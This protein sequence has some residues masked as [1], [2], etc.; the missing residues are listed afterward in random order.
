MKKKYL[1]ISLT[2]LLISCGSS[3]S[4]QSFFNEHKNEIGV[5]TFQVPNF[6]RSVLSSISPEMNGI[7]SNINDFKFITFNEISVEK[8]RELIQQINLVTANNYKDVLRQNT[9]EKTK[10]L[11]VIEDG[12][13]VK[14]VIVFN[15]TLAKTSVFYLKGTFNPNTLR[16]ISET[17]QFDDLSKKLLQSYQLPTNTGFNPNY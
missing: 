4:F 10:I 9:P 3:R 11:S 5:T 14:K 13:I 16:K 7:F 15:S 1:F 8:Q 17:N 2:L 12:N 6:M